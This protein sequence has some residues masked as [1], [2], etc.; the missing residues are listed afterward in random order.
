M[1]PRRKQQTARP[2]REFKLRLPDDVASRIE[3]KAAR[4]QRPQNRI[5][6]NELAAFPD[7]EKL[8]NLGEL[9]EDMRVVLAQQGARIAWNDLSD[10]CLRAVDAVL[11]AQ[12][13]GALQ[14]AIDKLRVVRTAMLAHKR[15]EDANTESKRK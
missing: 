9:V 13:S 3:E 14:A 7:L 2:G 11:K 12:G 4:E 1:A 15:T 8:R 6:I 5:V 10:E